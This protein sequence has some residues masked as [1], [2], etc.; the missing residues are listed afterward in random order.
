VYTTYYTC[1][2]TQNLLI[3]TTQRTQVFGL[4][5]RTTAVTWLV[6]FKTCFYYEMETEFVNIVEMN[7]ILPKVQ[8]VFCSCTAPTARHL[9][10]RN[11][12]TQLSFQH[13]P[14]IRHTIHRTV[15]LFRFSVTLSPAAPSLSLFHF[16]AL[17]HTLSSH[18]LR[19]KVTDFV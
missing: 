10:S 13:C 14:C 9:P 16:F 5:L 15:S 17:C 2:N 8:T 7:F 1:F 19:M 18:T 6:L 3:L 4:N 11:F 12:C